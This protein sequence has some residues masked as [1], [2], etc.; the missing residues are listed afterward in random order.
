MSANSATFKKSL[1]HLIGTD[2]ASARFTLMERLQQQHPHD[3]L[4]AALQ[5]S[6][7]G[8]A[9]HLRKA[10]RPRRQKDAQLRPLIVESFAQSRETYGAVR[11]RLRSAGVGPS[12]RQESHPPSHGRGGSASQAETPLSSC[13]HRAVATLT[14]WSVIGWPRCPDRIGRTRSGGATSLI[15]KPKRAGSIS[16]SLWMAAHVGASL[17][18]AR[19]T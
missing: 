4:A 17:T 3:A 7:S 15:S 9:A 14:L 11:V 16:P 8:F 1:G 12:L 18:I 5:V 19:R 2:D 6:E 13:H 10:E